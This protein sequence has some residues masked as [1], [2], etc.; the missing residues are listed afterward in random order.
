MGYQ[1]DYDHKEGTTIYKEYVVFPQF[2]QAE[3]FHLNQ[4]MY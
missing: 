4:E 1:K 2:F 3:P